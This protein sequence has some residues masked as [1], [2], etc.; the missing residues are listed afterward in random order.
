MDYRVGVARVHAY[1]KAWCCIQDPA[2]K[3]RIA[4]LACGEGAIA[5]VSKYIRDELMD[6]V[7]AQC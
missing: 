3:Q 4:Q 2:S 1:Y 5:N 7:K 6:G